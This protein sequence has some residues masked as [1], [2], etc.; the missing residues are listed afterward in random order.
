M[1]S[2]CEL[3]QVIPSYGRVL[4]GYDEFWRVLKSSYELRKFFHGAWIYCEL[5]RRPKSNNQYLQVTWTDCKFFLSAISVQVI[6][7]SCWLLQAT[8]TSVSVLGHRCVRWSSYMCPL[9]RLRIYWSRTRALLQHQDNRKTRR[10][11]LR[12][13]KQIKKD[14]ICWFYF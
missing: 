1:W 3:W 9:Q 5:W 12:L 2:D 8:N 14:Q 4:M 7:P 6:V 10:I 11:C 13:D